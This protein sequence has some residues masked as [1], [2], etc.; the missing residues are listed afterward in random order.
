MP[1][2]ESKTTKTI[3]KINQSDILEYKYIYDTFT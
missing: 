1:T 3:P 2:L